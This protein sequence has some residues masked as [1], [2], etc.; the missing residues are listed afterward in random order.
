MKI[1]RMPALAS[2][3]VRLALTACGPDLKEVSSAAAPSS[4]TASVSTTTAP[5][6]SRRESAD[7]HRGE[8]R[9]GELYGAEELRRGLS[10][11]RRD[12]LHRRTDRKLPRA[13]AEEDVGRH[14]Q[15]GRCGPH[16]PDHLRQRPR[17]RRVPLTT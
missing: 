14:D 6:D 16:G 12:R 11:E 10:V 4:P 13:G 1:R 2:A 17:G 5:A 15:A 3:A 8:D 9:G 7:G